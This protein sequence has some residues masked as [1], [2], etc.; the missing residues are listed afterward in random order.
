MENAWEQFAAAWQ[1]RSQRDLADILRPESLAFHFDVSTGR[2]SFLGSADASELLANLRRDA[3]RERI[4]VNSLDATSRTGVLSY[5]CPRRGCLHVCITAHFGT[6]GYLE[7]LQLST[8]MS[9]RW[10]M[11]S[12]PPG[13]SRRQIAQQS[14]S[15]SR[16]RSPPW[17]SQRA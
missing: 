1:S 11:D 9:S 14:S 17:R 8:R 13:S 12:G 16:S 4:L 3:Q 10:T 7:V 6:R 2:T 15:A 5:S